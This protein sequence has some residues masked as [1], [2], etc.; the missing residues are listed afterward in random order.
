MVEAAGAAG[1]PG[2]VI[3]AVL[4]RINH[5]VIGRSVVAGNTQTLATSK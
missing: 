1:I 5:F 4:E 3:Q 2:V